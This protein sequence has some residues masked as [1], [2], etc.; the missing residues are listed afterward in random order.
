MKMFKSMKSI[1]TKRKIIMEYLNKGM[2]L[3]QRILNNNLNDRLT[4]K[5]INNFEKKNCRPP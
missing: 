4:Y 3:H 1:Y 2:M 5:M